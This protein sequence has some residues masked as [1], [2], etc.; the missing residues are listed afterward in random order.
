[1]PG[2]N[3][4][5]PEHALGPACKTQHHMRIVVEATPLDKTVEISGETIEREAC[6]EGGEIEGVRAD[7]ARR[8]AKSGLRR[9]AAPDS[10]LGSG[11]LNRFG[12]P[13]MRIFHL[14]DAKIAKF[15]IG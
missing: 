4:A 13:V 5:A 11:C 12:E 3:L 1:I 8:A 9:I 2:R 6:H 14:Y 10:S 15:A 7:I